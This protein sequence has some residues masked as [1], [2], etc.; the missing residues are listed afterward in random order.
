MILISVSAAISLCLLARY[1]CVCNG[2][3]Y[4]KKINADFCETTEE[5]LLC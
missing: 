5:M 4:F 3:Q 2:R 1:V